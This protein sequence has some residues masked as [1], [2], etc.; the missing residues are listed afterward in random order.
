MRFVCFGIRDFMSEG[1]AEN[2]ID[3]VLERLNP[4]F[5]QKARFSKFVQRGKKI[6]RVVRDDP[7][8]QIY[9]QGRLGPRT[10]SV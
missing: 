9:Y 6:V 10:Y 1:L 5:T 4:D 7:Q 2:V 8:F 3:G